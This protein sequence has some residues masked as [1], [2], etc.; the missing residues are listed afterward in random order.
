MVEVFKTNVENQEQANFLI[1]HIQHTFVGYL[2]SF[3]LEDCDN[4]LRVKSGEG[5]V[6]VSAL[7][8]L[9]QRFGFFA[10]ILPDEI[11]IPET[12]LYN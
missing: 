3:D 12:V 10:E 7:V 1:G 9:L 6:D 11:I 2:A 5:F 8:H 4:I